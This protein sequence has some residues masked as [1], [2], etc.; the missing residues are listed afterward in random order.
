MSYDAIVIG[1]GIG[2]LGVAGILQSNGY[3]T[4][5][6]EKTKTSGGRSKTQ[7]IPGGWKLDTGTHCIDLGTKSAC[8][9]LLKI[10]GKEIPWTRN[11]EGAMLYDDDGVWKPMMEYLAMNDEEKKEL[12]DI[13]NWIKNATP[14]EID[15][16]DLVSLASLIKEKVTSPKI[17]EFMK[18]VGMVQ[19]TLTELESISAGEF[20]AI[21]QETLQATNEDAV[22]FDQVR[23]PVGGIVTMMKAM[24]DAFT[25]KGGTI[26]FKTSVRKINANP[27]QMTEIV[28]DNETFKAPV[29][30]I[31]TPIWDMLKFL[32]MDEMAK[33]VPEWAARM[34]SLEWETSA[35]IGFN[36]GTKVPLF[37]DPYYLSAWKVPGVNLPLQIL[38]HTNFDETI[39]PPGCM[40]AII[41]ACCTPDQ[42][43]DKEFREN[44]LK[45]FW[46]V[47]NKMFPKIEGNLVWKYD[48][49]FVGI[50]GLSRAPGHTGRYR[51]P[52]CLEEIP[53]LYFASDSFRGRGV[54][55]NNA[56]NSAMICAEEIMKRNN[57]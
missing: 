15:K 30:V 3:K 33:Y 48:G 46:E 22:P 10:L 36:I 43:R 24:Q 41:G 5:V 37:T 26:Q 45:V 25:E 49:F 7:D 17:A 55:M 50:D 35:S 23:M 47:V 2:G 28:T 27:G 54:G 19:T 11:I 52:V 14:Q 44:T 31:S 39:A 34:K 9:K 57:K 12:A 1:A 8:A 32:S 29:V 56:A 4:L 51:P 40:V 53:G 42:A 13:Q 16:L 38:G 21:Y 18:T 6:L 20:V